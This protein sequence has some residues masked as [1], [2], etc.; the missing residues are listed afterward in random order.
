MRTVKVYDQEIKL[1]PDEARYVRRLLKE[2]LEYYRLLT[3]N[4]RCTPAN[5]ATGE[6]LEALWIKLAR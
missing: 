6:F 2:H 4:L 3:S 5:K 1:S